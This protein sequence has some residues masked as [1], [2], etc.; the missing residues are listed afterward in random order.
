LMAGAAAYA[1]GR[2]GV[3]PPGEPGFRILGAQ[4]GRP[5][6]VVKGAPYS[7]DVSAEVTQNLGDGNKIHQV[8][9]EHVYRDN[10]GRT[11]RETTLAALGVAA[12]IVFIDDPVAGAS[13]A[14][15]LTA[16]TATKLP[17]RPP[18]PAGGPRLMQERRATNEFNTKIESL[19]R[20][21][22]SGI[23]AD[24]TRT[25]RTIP[26][27]QIGNLLPIQIVSERWYSPDLQTVVLER[28]SDP[29]SGE[30]IFQLT[31]IIRSEPSAALF[32]PPADFQAAQPAPRMR[33]GTGPRPELST[34]R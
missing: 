29:R 15:D 34:S 17:F 20:Q 13:Y 28:R 8:S 3:P 27:G 7:A 21:M 5:R 9:S 12:Q 2:R 14:L 19:G 11:R 16:R 23:P 6:P 32:A 31:N 22:I 4:P 30:T 1:Q 24:G 10:E 18:P 26:A 33:R 25:T